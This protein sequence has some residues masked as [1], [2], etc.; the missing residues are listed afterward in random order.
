[1]LHRGC[2]RLVAGPVY[3]EVVQ[4]LTYVNAFGDPIVDEVRTIRC[5]WA[6]RDARYFDFRFDVLSARDRGPQ[7]FLFMMRL[8]GAFDIPNTGRVTN[9]AGHPVP[10]PNREDRYYRAA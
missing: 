2:R 10:A 4:D 6:S 8:P 7:P 9:A 3:G 5:W 1:M